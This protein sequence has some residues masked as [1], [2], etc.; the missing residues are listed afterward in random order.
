MRVAIET[1]AARPA[2]KRPYVYE[3]LSWQQRCERACPVSL[4]SSWSDGRWPVDWH[5]L[6]ILAS[7]PLKLRA[8]AWLMVYDVESCP[9]SCLAPLSFEAKPDP[10]EPPVLLPPDALWTGRSQLPAAANAHRACLPERDVSP[11]EQILL[12]ASRQIFL[13]VHLP[14]PAQLFPALAYFPDPP[15]KNEK[16][17]TRIKYQLAIRRPQS[18]VYCT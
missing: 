17:R 3:L 13:R 16:T 18:A 4:R 11:R 2:S 6:S 8:S 5:S 14:A 15:F 10:L 7:M 1:A 9:P 12:L